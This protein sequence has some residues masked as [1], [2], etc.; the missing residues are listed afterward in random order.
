MPWPAAVIY[1]MKPAAAIL[2][3]LASEAPGCLCGL[4]FRFAMAAR[5]RKE[6]PAK[7]FR[8]NNDGPAG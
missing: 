4:R 7:A 5:D 3:A 8:F 2:P 6:K 1:N